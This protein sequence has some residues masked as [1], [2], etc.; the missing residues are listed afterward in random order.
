M[1]F[2]IRPSDSARQRKLLTQVGSRLPEL[3]P[4]K[5]YSLEAIVGSDF[6]DDMDGAPT[7]V[8]R[9]FSDLV[10]KGR[11]PFVRAG[12]TDDRHNRYKYTG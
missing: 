3:K 1:D 6:W 10:S 8:G 12:F 11:V 5:R 9:C 4:R 7:T 2:P